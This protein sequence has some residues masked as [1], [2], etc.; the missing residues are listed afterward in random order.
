MMASDLRYQRAGEAGSGG[1][2]GDAD[3]SAVAQLFADPSRAAVLMGLYDGRALPASLLASEAG[4]SASTMSGHLSRLLDAGL[5]TVERHGRHRYYRLAGPHVA[6][7][8]E[9]LA[10]FSQPKPVRSLREGTRGKALRTARTCYDH[11]AG[12][13]G[14][15]I[16]STMIGLGYLEGGDGEYRPERAVR[17]RLSGYGRDVTYDLTGRGTC[18]LDGLSI[19]IPVT[20]RPAIRYCV[21]W[22]EQRHHVAGS[23]GRAL[24]D[25]ALAE[26]WIVRAPRG[27][28]VHV[29][30]RG[31][32]ALR[33]HFG[34]DWP[35]RDTL[36][37][38]R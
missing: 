10:E 17:D 26:G 28:A 32:E 35:A 3:V 38:R 6:E 12:R 14:V 31:R 30:G 37:S 13:L 19:R 36:A 16:M 33:D 9:R 24:L 22:S 1:R 29:T 2:G 25:H 18:F 27:R 15:G 4:V 23:L 34:L 21:D 8:L 5:V 7:I 11:L 20:R